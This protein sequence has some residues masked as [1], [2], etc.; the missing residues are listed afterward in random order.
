MTVYRPG[1]NEGQDYAPPVVDGVTLHDSIV[2]MS[3]MIDFERADT[4]RLE[5]LC[6]H[7]CITPEAVVEAAL[8]RGL[9]ELERET[10]S[11]APETPWTALATR[12]ARSLE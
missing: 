7:S 1:S 3:M 6:D 10:R 12:N 8:K 4:E 11:E 2:E 9:R 5:R